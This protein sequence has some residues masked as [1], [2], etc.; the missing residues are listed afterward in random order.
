M[1]E[2]IVS[3]DGTGDFVTIKEAIKKAKENS[4]IYIKT[5]IYNEKLLITKKLKIIGDKE[6]PPIIQTSFSTVCTITAD[7]DISYMQFRNSGKIHYDNKKSTVLIYSNS[8]FHNCQFSDSYN[9]NVLVKGQNKTPLFVDCIFNNPK[10][11]YNTSATHGSC[12]TYNNCII[13]NSEIGASVSNNSKITFINCDIK[14]C[15]NGIKGTNNPTI[16]IEKCHIHEIENDGVKIQ[17]GIL[18]IKDTEIYNCKQNGIKAK[19]TSKINMGNCL[20]YNTDNGILGTQNSVIN[21]N[22]TNI[23]NCEI[24]ACHLDNSKSTYKNCKF[25]GFGDS[26]ILVK[27]NGEINI[28]NIYIESAKKTGITAYDNSILSVNNTEITKIVDVAISGENK[29]TTI[30][31]TK[32]HTTKNLGIV[33]TNS[34]LNIK[35]TEITNTEKNGLSINNCNTPT[36]Q[37]VTIKDNKNIGLNLLHVTTPNFTNVIIENNNIGINTILSD[38]VPISP[39][40]LKT[41]TT[42]L[43]PLPYVPEK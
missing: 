5:G 37:N 10:G 24:G 2:I 29:E 35:D 1:E 22:N 40:T 33:V 28:D 6:Y 13:K 27:D 12:P 26:A 41:N 14:N 23:H 4:T 21:S 39:E 25:Q 3:K 11:H 16:N 8:V 38:P 34:K 19:S 17:D 42:P 9:I 31:N 15:Q 20:I 36:L 18:E 30:E 32:V 7:T 43:Q